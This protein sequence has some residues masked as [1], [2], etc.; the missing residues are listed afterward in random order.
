MAF[1]N[2]VLIQG[3]KIINS[4]TQYTYPCSFLSVIW[5]VAL[6]QTNSRSGSVQR[7]ALS[8]VKLSYIVVTG[9]HEETT[10]NGAY[11]LIIGV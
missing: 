8:E 7:I 6:S 5:S 1:S 9:V 4:I 11:F 3:M 10:S 2:G